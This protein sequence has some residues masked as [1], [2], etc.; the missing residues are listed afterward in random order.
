MRQTI[1][2]ITTLQIKQHDLL[3]ILSENDLEEMDFIRVESIE[4]AEN[5]FF[6]RDILLVIGDNSIPGIREILIEMKQDEFFSHVPVILLIPRRT[7]QTI[8]KALQEGFDVCIAEEEV[9]LLLAHQAIPLIKNH[10]RS[11]I[12]REEV[13]Q[14]QEK[15]IHDFILLDLIKDYIPRTIYN[16]ALKCAHQ[17]KIWIPEEET[18]LTIVFGDI[19][20][21]TPHTQNMEPKNVISYLN[22]A[23]DVVSRLVYS[24][25]GDIDKYIGDAF[26]AVF[27][28]PLDALQSM[29]AV[30]Q[31]MRE[32]NRESEPEDKILFRIGMHTG[33]VI[34]GNVG[35]NNRFDNTLIGDTV[36]TAARLEQMGSPGG[37]LI[38]EATR[39]L[40]NLELPVEYGRQERLKGRTG[41][42]T[43][44]EVFEFLDTRE[45]NSESASL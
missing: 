18:T 44:W 10:L 6:E 26:L 27:S 1:L 13:S 24:H 5:L 3:K 33:P 43:V 25:S 32:I 17:Q 23:F 11:D 28:D 21:F 12:S 4:E 39:K 42:E 37:V 2:A 7:R 19:R 22:R 36:N 8:Q 20:G 41:I 29:I 30:Q 15:S 34:R 45:V 38:S 9:P 31:E 16:I 35:G 14:L 40:L